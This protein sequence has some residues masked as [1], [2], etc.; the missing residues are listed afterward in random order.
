VA[1]QKKIVRL[2]CGGSPKKYQL[3]VADKVTDTLK[4]ISPAARVA[5]FSK[6][7]EL[8]VADRIFGG[9]CRIGLAGTVVENDEGYLFIY[10]LFLL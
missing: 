7:L 3:A 9:L 1:N 6:I 10:F 2:V 5:N 8:A 4:K